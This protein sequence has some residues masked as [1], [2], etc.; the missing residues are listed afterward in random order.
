[1]DE[2]EKK[3]GQRLQLARKRAGL[4]QQQLCQRVGLSY[5]TL[6]KIERG[7]IRSPSVFTVAAIA[8]ATD[9]PLEEILS[10]FIKNTAVL[11]PTKKTSKTGVKFVYF[12]ISGVLVNFS[13]KTFADIAKDASLPVD[14]VE[15][16]YWRYN[17]QL[18]KSEITLTQLNQM[19]GSAFG[20][21]DFDWER[22]YFNNLEIIRQGRELFDW[23][24]QNYE[25][26]L[27]SNHV[28][29]EKMQQKGLV[30]SQ[31][32]AAT[33]DSSKAGTIKPEAKIYKIAQ[34]R[35]GVTAAEILLIDNERPNLVAADK[36]NWQTAWFDSFRATESAERI[37]RFLEF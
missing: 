27:M 23:T 10:G 3:L 11:E 19:L 14:S 31:G 35:S 22:Y 9:T 5:S 17:D 4:T 25:V 37:K 21:A 12:D 18:N 15:A 34:K 13:H 8:S 30:P 28:F 29:I 26:G 1:M 20:L 24:A 6:A 33:V 36:L 32:L 16:T 7:A 2:G